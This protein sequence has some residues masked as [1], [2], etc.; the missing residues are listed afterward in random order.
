VGVESHVGTMAGLSSAQRQVLTAVKRRGEASADEVAEM[1][2]I[3]P[4]AVRQHLAILR[5]GGL[6]ASRQERGRPGR[7]A[8]LYHSTELGEHLFAAPTTGEFSVE[9]LRHIEDED[10]DLIPRLF[11]RRR[12]GRVERYREQLAGKTLGDTVASLAAILDAEGYMADVDRLAGDG[13][14]LTLHSCAIWAVA[15]HYGLACT[16]ELEFLQEV[17]PNSDITR[18]IHKVAGAFIC[19]YEIRAV[20]TPSG[21]SIPGAAGH[22]RRS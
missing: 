22:S 13:Y 20:N 9:L 18:V 3:T 8:D 7:P 5:T 16:T 15:S 21:G 11:Q 6:V 19:A 2:G 10:P 4:S 1:L 14:R 17:I 12:R